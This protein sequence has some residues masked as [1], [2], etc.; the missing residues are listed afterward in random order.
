MSQERQLLHALVGILESAHSREVERWIEERERLLSKAHREGRLR[1]RPGGQ[2]VMSTTHG[3]S[4]TV[5]DF[6]GE[7]PDHR[8][9][10]TRGLW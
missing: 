7:R 5:E 2:P 1:Y 8:H 9:P 3:V 6:V 4:A 10:S